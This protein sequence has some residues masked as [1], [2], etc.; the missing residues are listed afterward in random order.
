MPVSVE[1]CS[2]SG[3]TSSS[4]R[5]EYTTILF[6]SDCCSDPHALSATAAATAVNIA[7][8]RV[9]DFDIRLAFPMLGLKLPLTPNPAGKR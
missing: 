5:P 1:N 8:N 6:S 2:I 4:L 9:N 3:L 7:A